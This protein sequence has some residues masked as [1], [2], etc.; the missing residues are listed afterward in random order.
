[1]RFRTL[2]WLCFFFE[3]II[4]HWRKIATVR[5]KYWII[6]MKWNTLPCKVIIKPWTMIPNQAS[7]NGNISLQSIIL[8]QSLF[9]LN[10]WLFLTSPYFFDIINK[11]CYKAWRDNHLR[12]LIFVKKLERTSNIFCFL[13]GCISS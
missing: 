8:I 6:K 13:D 11:N 5:T 1:M 12:F 4:H 2:L 9:F 10:Y 3:I 7:K